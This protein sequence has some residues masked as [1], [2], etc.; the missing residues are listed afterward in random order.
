[1]EGEYIMKK[2]TTL[3]AFGGEV[4]FTKAICDNKDIQMQLNN[5]LIDKLNFD[6]DLD[7]LKYVPEVVLDFGCRPDI[8]VEQYKEPTFV[9]E[10]MDARGNLD[11]PHIMKSIAY[12]YQADVTDVVL[13]A[14]D[15]SRD[16]VLLVEHLRSFGHSIFLVTYDIF[17]VDNQMHVF[18][19]SNSNPMQMVSNDSPRKRSN[20]RTKDRQTQLNSD[21]YAKYK[22]RLGLTHITTVYSSRNSYANLTIYANIRAQRSNIEIATRRYD[23][24]ALAEAITTM[25]PD[26]EIATTINKSS[27]NVQIKGFAHETNLVETFE[28]ICQSLDDKTLELKNAA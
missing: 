3:E 13:L 2:L 14:E 7:N 28:K 21:F 20:E 26:L 8:V 4:P 19:R 16:A 27:R 15:I 22:E 17:Q 23:L 11:M 5:L 25:F 12:A 9:V 24:E 18:F 1:M 6:L 10:C